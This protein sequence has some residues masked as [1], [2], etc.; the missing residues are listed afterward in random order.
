MAYKCEFM[1]NKLISLILLATKRLYCIV[2]YGEYKY[3]PY[4]AQSFV[5]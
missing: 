3:K 2:M 4:K 1:E 5:S